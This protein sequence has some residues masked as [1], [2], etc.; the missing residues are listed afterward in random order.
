MLLYVILEPVNVLLS[1]AVEL[2]PTVPLEG[3]ATLVYVLSP[4]FASVSP[5]PQ[6]TAT[7]APAVQLTD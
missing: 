6:F 5:K 1:K 2:F 3:P 7:V 4:A